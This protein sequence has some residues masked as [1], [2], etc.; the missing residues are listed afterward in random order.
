MW[1]QP[2]TVQT[3]THEKIIWMPFT[4]DG[5]TGTV[6]CLSL[7]TCLKK[8]RQLVPKKRLCGSADPR[9]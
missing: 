9:V 8:V 1:I 3:P 7:F 5:E 6:A 4:V 2:S